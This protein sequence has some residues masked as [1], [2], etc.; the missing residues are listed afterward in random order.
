M[1]PTRWRTALAKTFL[2]ALLGAIAALPAQATPCESAWYCDPTDPAAYRVHFDITST[3]PVNITGIIDFFGPHYVTNGQ[4]DFSLSNP[5]S[6][7]TGSGT[8]DAGIWW[9]EDNHFLLGMAGSHLVFMMN[10]ATAALMTG[11]NFDNLINGISP[12]VP[13]PFPVS[14]AEDFIIDRMTNQP[15]EWE[16]DIWSL[17]DTNYRPN[18]LDPTILV[19]PGST[20][21]VLMSFTDGKVLGTVNI[22]LSPVPEPARWALILMGTLA[23]AGWLRRPAR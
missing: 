12:Q 3:T 8:L 23:L 9:G 2:L 17:F 20:T 4:G 14:H 5:P 7:P 22:T 19:G 15:S 11:Q 10:P 1:K 21:G 18:A 13:N 6:L 16:H